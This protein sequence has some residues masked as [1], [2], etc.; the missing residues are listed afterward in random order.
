MCCCC[1]YC[2]SHG[3]VSFTMLFCFV[4]YQ[5]SMSVYLMDIYMVNGTK[6][7]NGYM[8]LIKVK[9]PLHYQSVV[10]VFCNFPGNKGKNNSLKF[11]ILSSSSSVI[12]LVLQVSRFTFHLRFG[13]CHELQFSLHLSFLLISIFLSFPLQLTSCKLLLSELLLF[14]SRGHA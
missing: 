11:S 6:Y 2:R 4:Q 12:D 1:C 3:Y 8:A 14:A 5:Y 9:A 10:N 13:T 7:C